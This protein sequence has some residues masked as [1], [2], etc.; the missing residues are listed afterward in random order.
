MERSSRAGAEIGTLRRR[1]WSLARKLSVFIALLIGVIMFVFGAVVVREVRARGYDEIIRAGYQQVLQLNL[2]AKTLVEPLRNFKNEAEFKAWT[3]KYQKESKAHDEKF[4]Q[5]ILDGDPRIKDI[6]VF[7]ARTPEENPS[8]VLLKG[9]PAKSFT[10]PH[11]P[12]LQVKVPSPDPDVVVYA[13]RYDNEPVLFFRLPLEKENPESKGGLGKTYATANLILSVQEI[14]AEVRS[15]VFDILLF[16]LVCVAACVALSLGLASKVVSPINVLVED[17]NAVSQGNLRHESTVPATTSD[18]IGLLAMAFN[19]MT[20]NLREARERE[21]DAERIASELS[22]AQAI[23]AKLLPDKLPNLPGID[24]YSAYHCAKEVGGDYYDF[25]PIGD[26]EH[27]AFCVADVSGKGIPGSM[28]MGTTRTIL[29]MMAVNNLSA[30]DV[31]SKTN[32][33]VA[34]DLKRGMFVTCLYTILN[35]RTWELTVANAGHNPLLLYRAATQTIEK[36][37]PTGIAL[38]FDKGPLFNKNLQE[39]KFKLQ[40]GDR[41]VLYTDGV[42]ESM[43]EQRE[44]WTDE[45][46]DEFTLQHATLPSSDYIRLLLKALEGHQGRAEQHD[47]I[48]VVTFRLT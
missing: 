21:R 13:G 42:V 17:I 5:K 11:E 14:D 8:T 31:L 45:A 40:R 12:Y 26:N 44:E 22:T 27:L 7:I 6:A 35:V 24:V 39:Q 33:H 34:R 15:L 29:R 48:T 2:F 46:L 4:I 36:I 38:G 28:V 10:P 19:R 1:G 25:I 41:V 9:Q 30:S 43:N 47:D 23:H 16:G 18:E 32:S 37:R 3:D 20:R